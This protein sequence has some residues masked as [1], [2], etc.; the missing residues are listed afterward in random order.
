MQGFKV[1]KRTLCMC[2]HHVSG[3][4]PLPQEPV[5]EAKLLSRVTVVRF[6]SDAFLGYSECYLSASINFSQYEYECNWYINLTTRKFIC[7]YLG[8]QTYEAAPS[9][10][11]AKIILSEVA[12]CIPN[13]KITHIISM[14]THL[15][16]DMHNI[17]QYPHIDCCW[18]HWSSSVRKLVVA[19]ASV[20]FS[21]TLP[22]HACSKKLLL[23]T[24]SSDT[25]G[26]VYSGIL[27]YRLHYLKH[28]FHCLQINAC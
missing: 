21:L 24:Q 14:Y 12:K 4:F 11:L 13:D 20:I 1:T 19:R 23:G 8:V 16:C 6:L 7:R 2:R 25:D 5:N 28:C 27:H 15:L 10:H 9:W 18:Y 3:L 22:S 26:H 17:D